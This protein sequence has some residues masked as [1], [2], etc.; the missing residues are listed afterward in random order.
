M[1]RESPRCTGRPWRN[2]VLEILFALL[3]AATVSGQSKIDS[4]FGMRVPMRDGVH[5]AAN[6]FRPA[7]SGRW[8]ALLVR[9]PYGKG[10]ALAA[11]HR[12]F[13]E[14]GFALV[15]QDVRGFHDSEGVFRPLDQEGPDGEDTIAWM[16][17]QSWC[18][19]NIGMFGGSYLGIVQWQTALRN[20]PH[21]KA[22][23]PVVSGYD[24][25]V[26][27]FYSR[28]GAMKLG[29]RLLWISENLRAPGFARPDFNQFIYHLPLR[30]ADQAVSGETIEWYQRALN[31]PA[32]DSFWRSVSTREKLDRI[33]VPVFAAGGWFDNYGQ[34]DLEAFA[35]LRKLGRE[36][37]VLIGPWPHNFA[38]RLAVDFGPQSAVALRR[39]QFQWFDHWL[40]G[41]DTI[42]EL[43]P[44]RIFTM[45]VNRWQDLDTWP[46]ADSKSTMYY[47]AGKGNANTVY[48]DGKLQT[49]RARRLWSDQYLD[50]PKKPVPTLGGA[51]CCNSRRMPPG[52]RDQR[53]VEGRHDVLVYTGD[54]LKRELEVTG[55]VR[56]LLHVS[57]SARDTDFTAKLVDVALDGSAMSVTD[58]ILRLRYRGGLDH[59]ELAKPGEVY[60]INIDAG[61]TS[62]VFLR[63]HRIR[64]EIASTNFPRFDRNPNTGKPIAD[65][66]ELRT[67]R[68][69]VLHGGA[70]ES[71]LVLPVVRRSSTRAALP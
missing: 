10:T 11:N 64:L 23:F 9:T 51:V 55:V 41:K 54:P 49:R 70:Y 53:T 71:A 15:V 25:Y 35:A 46:P 1:P 43:A 12:A 32:Y 31:H 13:V 62:I 56:V 57:T 18:D 52:P 14:H 26:D 20:P 34:S 40:K 29:H 2:C 7:A 66:L 45:G 42:A 16:A 37:H 8:P 21:L 59:P 67:A 65:E 17:S 63:G 30:N 60:A 47:L 36:A 38:D 19:G 61:T 3:L 24:D 68:Q 50:D 48:G 22:I 44:A 33:R 5:L 4:Q 69:T 39:L 28:G 27:R 6:V 58:G